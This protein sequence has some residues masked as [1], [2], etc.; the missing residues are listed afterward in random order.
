MKT[1]VVT[2]LFFVSAC[3]INLA[4]KVKPENVPTSV[5]SAFKSKFPNVTKVKWSLENAN[6]YEA[7]FKL[8]GKGKSANFDKDGKW[9]ETETEI[10]RSELPKVVIDAIAKQYPGYKIEEVEL[11]ETNDIP[12]FY[13]VNIELKDKEYDIEI[14]SN[15]E[16]IKATEV[17]GKDED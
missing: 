12:S 7:E 10:S 17:T 3:S 14:K 15:G 9:L 4:Q 1:L 16:I 2:V 5:M 13:S 8:D 11:A 6:E